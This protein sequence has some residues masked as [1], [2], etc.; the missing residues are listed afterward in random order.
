MQKSLNK[1]LGAIS[2]SAIV[3][4]AVILFILFM[5]ISYFRIGNMGAEQEALIEGT[6]RNNQQVLSSCSTSIRNISKIPDKY[7]NDFESIL[8][9]EME[10]RYGGQGTDRVAKFIQERAL[11]YDSSMLKTIQNEILACEAKFSLAQG[12]LIS[13][14]TGYEVMQNSAFTGAF[15]RANGYPKKDLSKFK[16]ILDKSTQEQFESGTRQDYDT[17]K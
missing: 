12:K 2:A 14:Q 17:G 7:R 3:A 11:N 8:K 13:L 4:I 9:T 10:A 5:L 15:L 1:Q 6:Y 16:I